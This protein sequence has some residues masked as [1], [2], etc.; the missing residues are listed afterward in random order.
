[1]DVEIKFSPQAQDDLDAIWTFLNV[2]CS[3]PE[4]ASR[5][6]GRLLDSI[7]LLSVIPESGTP[8]NAR[9]LMHSD[10]RFI[11][12][13]HLLAFYRFK[14]DCIFIDRILDGRSDYLNKLFGLEDSAIDYY[15]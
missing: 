15:V 8:L 9:C 7:D 2:E 11:T 3:N 6:I 5:T 10:Y 12:A 1:M 4:T 13:G 14:R